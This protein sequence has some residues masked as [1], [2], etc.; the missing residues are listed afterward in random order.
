MTQQSQRQKKVQQV[1]DQLRKIA[2]YADTTLQAREVHRGESILFS[3][4][5]EKYIRATEISVMLEM[6]KTAYMGDYVLCVTKQDWS[7]LPHLLTLAPRSYTSNTSTDWN[8]LDSAQGT[9]LLPSKKIQEEVLS[10]LKEATES[11]NY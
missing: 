10:L 1:K 11:T 9:T 2:Q 5:L 6:E 3:K 4:K 8:I 7:G